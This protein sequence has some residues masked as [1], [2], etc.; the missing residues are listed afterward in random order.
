[1]PSVAYAATAMAP[2]VSM[3]AGPTGAAPAAAATPSFAAAGTPPPLAPASAFAPAPALSP[4]PASAKPDGT[5]NAVL[6]V[7]GVLLLGFGALVVAIIVFANPFASR[8]AGGSPS[9][10][11][12]PPKEVPASKDAC[13]TFCAKLAACTGISDPQCESACKHTPAFAA[14]ATREGCQAIASCTIGATC[15]GK[16]P[17]GTMSCRA[18]ADCEGTCLMHGGDPTSCNCACMHLMSADRATEIVA[19]NDCALVRCSQSCR[20]P[21]VSTAA[22]VRCFSA[23]CVAE[24]LAC[25]AR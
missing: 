14:C 24:S 18:T 11:V 3:V 15:G 21:S 20:P 5:R 22:C 17:Q 6:V 25:K 12:P 2:A 19:N 16:E 7:A 23:S 1:V 10:V 9:A 4:A 13:P 8:P